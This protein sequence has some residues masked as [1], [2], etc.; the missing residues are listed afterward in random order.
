MIIHE[1]KTHTQFFEQVAYGGKNF[2]VRKN[3]RAYKVGDLLHLRNYNPE[4]KLYK[5]GHIVA[6]V[7]YVLE[8][9]QFGIEN[10]YVVMGIKIINSQ[11]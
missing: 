11:Y 2:E 3:D 10:G 4:E 9:G 6:E 8:G 1:L 7:I 5:Y